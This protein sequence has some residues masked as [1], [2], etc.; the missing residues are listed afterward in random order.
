MAATDSRWR[1]IEARFIATE[2][3]SSVKHRLAIPQFSIVVAARLVAA[4]ASA[5]T[6]V[7]SDSIKSRWL[8]TGFL[9]V[10]ILVDNDWDS[11]WCAFAGIAQPRLMGC[12]AESQTAGGVSRFAFLEQVMRKLWA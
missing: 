4:C 11:S 12:E 7:M 5:M 6:S 10:D 2:T 1:A 9:S 8:M 3:P